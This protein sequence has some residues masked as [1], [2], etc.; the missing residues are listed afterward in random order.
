MAIQLILCVETNKK[1]DIDWIYISEVIKYLYVVN[2]QI[3]ISKVYMDSKSKYKSNRVSK[4]IE[5]KTKAFIIGETKVIYCIDTDEYEKSIEH[6]KELDEISSFCNANGYDLIWFCHDVEDVFLGKK[7]SDSKKVQEAGAFRSKRG[8]EEIR[9]NK[10]SSSMK[11]AHTSNIL[12]ILDQYLT[13]KYQLN[14]V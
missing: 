14:N 10:L 4:E 7:V 9:L 2:N 8:I 6:E 13:R 1:A 11:G 12:C 5:K 3:K